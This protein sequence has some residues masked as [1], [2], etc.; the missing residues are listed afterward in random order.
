MIFILRTEMI[1]M[2]T[3]FRPSTA[4]SHLDDLSATCHASTRKGML[5]CQGV[6]LAAVRRLC[7]GTAKE[8]SY[9]P[10]LSSQQGS[11]DLEEEDCVGAADALAQGQQLHNFI[12]EYLAS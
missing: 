8:E 7:S 3:T 6:Q 12:R 10:N 4:Q 1:F 9:S 2:T 5:P 11:R